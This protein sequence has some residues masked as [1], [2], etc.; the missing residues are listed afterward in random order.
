MLLFPAVLFAPDPDGLSGCV[1]PDLM[2]NASGASPDAAIRDAA[3]IVAEH[4]RDLAAAGEPFPEPSPVDQVDLDGGTLVML[5][6][7]IPLAAA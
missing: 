2:V 7:T 6:I 4:L 3:A 5:P 1:V